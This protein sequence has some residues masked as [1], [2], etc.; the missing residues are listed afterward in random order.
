MLESKQRSW[1]KM[2]ETTLVNQ[3]SKDVAC[4]ALIVGA[5]RVAKSEESAALS[6]STKEVDQALDGLISS[7]YAQ[8]EFKGN[9]GETVQ[10]YTMGKL[11]AR[12]VIVVGLGAADKLQNHTLRRASGIAVRLAQSKGAR[13]VALALDIHEDG[14]ERLQ[15]SV[16]GA[17]LGVYGFKKYRSAQNNGRLIEQLVF[18]STDAESQARQEALKRGMVMA[19]ASNFARDLVNEQPAVLT[20]SELANRARTMAEHYGLECT[21]L[22]PP[23]MEGLGMGGL[24]AVGKGSATPPRLI[25][26]RYRGAP[27]SAEPEL[28]LVGK[29]I[30]FDTGGISIKPAAGM[31]SMKGDMGGGA[32][33]LGAMQIIAALKPRINVLAL[34][35]SAENMPDG[36]SY[37]PGDILRLMNG[38]TIEIINTDAEG[39]LVLADALSYAVKEGCS[40]IIDI[41]TLT[42]ACYVAL[43]GKRGGLFCNDDALRDGLMAAGESTG[44]KFWPMPIDEEYQEN[45]ES[46]V[47]DIKQ[48]GPRYGGAISAAKILEHFVGEARWAHLDIAGTEFV[49]EKQA[50]MEKG[51]TGFGARA[52]AEL[53]LSRAW[54]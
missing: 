49:E 37:R 19:E 31:E 23:Q 1:R 47:A 2:M 41:A 33:V 25:I 52:L 5:T 27:Q 39:R 30:T 38:K 35:P 10:I 21:I 53:V 46:H 24:L 3:A 28:A 22:E 20:P 4:D 14:V 50:F 12:Y 32:A 44:E 29:G 42:G 15:A 13:R 7:M 36:A 8:G 11:A 26:L 45:I 18:V 48:G 17:L 34:V 9:A 16:E 40:P 51:A 43:G 54:Q 6:S